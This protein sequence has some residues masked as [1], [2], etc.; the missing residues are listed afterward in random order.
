MKRPSFQF[1]PADYRN[2]SKL[3]RC[4]PAARG[5]WLDVMCVLHDSDEYGV[6]RWPLAELAQAAGVPVKLA[7]ELSVK[8]VL[9]GADKG[10]P[11]YVF[12]PRHAGKDGEPVMLVEAGDGPCWYCSRF[13]RD[14]YI[15]QRRGQSTRYSTD[16]QPPKPGP[17]DEP[18]A[19]PKP[20]IG[21]PQ[22][23]GSTSPSPSTSKSKDQLPMSSD[24]DL[25]LCPTGT[26]VD[27]YHE[28]MPMNPRLK[29]LSDARKSA[30]RARWVDAAKLDCE[31]FGYN[32]KAAGLVAWRKFFAM[33]AESKFLTG[34]A[35]APPGK[36]AFIADIDF[37][38]SP[39]GFAK[40][41][42]NKYHRDATPKP[43]VK[44]WT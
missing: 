4:S 6:C 43:P 10:A 7:R 18:K 19:P 1:Y 9:K 38:F 2:N 12:T 28:L 44:D 33:C 15:R 21:E 31:P 11:D 30:I 37:L 16:N 14:E 3:R 25:R 40:T 29:V 20:P 36:P 42:E 39:G 26:L 24:D 8:D 5:A 23:D 35:P 27:L 22:G 13:V 17:H 34:L 32:T 41:L